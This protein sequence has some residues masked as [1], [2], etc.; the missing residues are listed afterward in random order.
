[1]EIGTLRSATIH[2][3]KIRLTSGHTTRTTQCFEK[4][5]RS[6]RQHQWLNA[7]W[8]RSLQGTMQA[9]RMTVSQQALLKFESETSS[10]TFSCP[11][12]A[13]QRRNIR[14]PCCA[15]RAQNCTRSMRS[16]NTRRK[17]L[18]YEAEHSHFGTAKHVEGVL[19]SQVHAAR[20]L[21]VRGRQQ[22]LCDA[23]EP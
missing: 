7:T 15:S 17:N 6:V 21:R 11:V 5:I 16:R 8:R 12:E 1:M 13:T 9:A 22:K 20:D 18:R 3:N 23:M 14:T 10:A 4:R 2:C 19:K